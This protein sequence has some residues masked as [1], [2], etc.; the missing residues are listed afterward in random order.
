MSLM[1]Q[2][3]YNLVKTNGKLFVSTIMQPEKIEL[4]EMNWLITKQ[5]T[6]NYDLWVLVKVF[7]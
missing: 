1:V 6:Q 7:L 2:V 4:I 3:C 5:T